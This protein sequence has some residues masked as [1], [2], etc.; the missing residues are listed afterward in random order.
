MDGN[1]L[2][3]LGAAALVAV[4]I[5]GLVLPLL[6][7]VPLLFGGLWLAAWIDGYAKVGI[8]IVV[9]LGVLAALAFVVDYVAAM[10]GVKKVGASGLAMAD[11]G[12]GALGGL[13]LGLPGLIVGPIVGAAAGE[14]IARR[15]TAQA[16]KAGIAAG[17]GF[18]IAVVAK[19]GLA[20]AMLAVFAFAYFI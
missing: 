4:G 20:V 13:F 6:P 7:G 12:L 9:V 18:V 10:F 5:A 16:T 15:D 8:G 11:A 14:F 17:F 1:I 2:L 19:L 3:W